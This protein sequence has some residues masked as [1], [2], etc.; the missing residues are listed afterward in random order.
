MRS[1]VLQSA[2][3]LSEHRLAA[4]SE[5]VWPGWVRALPDYVALMKPRIM[6]LLLIT[7]LAAVLI[8]ASTTSISSLDTL[9]LVVLTMFGGALASGGASALNQYI[10][11]DID[12]LMSR[13]S[14]RPLP[15]G[16]LQP[17]QV[18]IFGLTLTVLSVLL[19]VLWV[20]VLSAVLALGGNLF[21]VVVYT[22]WLKRS[23]PQNIVIGGIA[24]AI[25]PL[26]GWAAVRND[27][28]LPA[29]LLFVIITLWTPPH[30]WS[31]SL[32]T[33][34][35]YSRAGIPM[36]PVVRGLDK[37]RINIVVY[38]VLLVAFTLA[39]FA[40]HVMGLFYL[41]A[42]AGLGAYFLFRALTLLRLGTTRLARACFVYSNIYLA[43]LFAAMVIDR[44]IA[45][46]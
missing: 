18:L 29:I 45:L 20:N 46:S 27:V 40:T 16:R 44:L 9:R 37:T 34:R 17:R 19:F 7:T 26:V 36:L 30:F 1:R 39:L 4:A 14:K 41:A 31:L 2:T 32:L 25:P 28:A 13:T 24:G 42:A 3:N 21:Y 22:C 33:Q 5:T 23:T 35:D 12:G 11:R 8:A 38:T 15:A 6:V 43:L 10:D